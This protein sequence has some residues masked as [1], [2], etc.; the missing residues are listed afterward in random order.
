MKCEH[1]FHIFYVV[2][3]HNSNIAIARNR[4]KLALVVIKAIAHSTNSSPKNLYNESIRGGGRIW[5][6]E[7]SISNARIA[8][9]A[10]CAVSFS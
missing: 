4:C 2:R 7:G 1:I 8:L 6:L 5:P 9:A 3:L 10:L